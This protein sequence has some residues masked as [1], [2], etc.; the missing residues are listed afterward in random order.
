MDSI[1][2]IKIPKKPKV[3]NLFISG[4]GAVGG[5]YGLGILNLIKKLEEKKIIKVCSISGSSIGSLLG[6]YYFDNKL[7]VLE[8]NIKKATK[9][10]KDNKN[11]DK[12]KEIIFDDIKN[13][14]LENVNKKLFIKYHNLEN[15][16]VI[17]EFEDIN[18]LK[19][20][21]YKSCFLPYYFEDKILIDKSCD[22]CLP[23]LTVEH[24][25]KDYNSIF[26]KLPT[27]NFFS[28]KTL[29]NH[30]NVKNNGYMD[31]YNFF[32][33]KSSKYISYLSDWNP[34]N[35]IF[36]RARELFLSMIVLNILYY[37]E[38]KIKYFLPSSLNLFLKNIYIDIINLTSFY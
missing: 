31:A 24:L 5:V 8:N 35:Y 13:I 12:L 4:G 18:Q 22:C 19:D 26:I 2:N 3:V 37:Y 16:Q 6:C 27:N 21:L 15:K 11:R 23:Y 25:N 1:I 30:K 20:S 17:S 29:I 14:N 34:H 9:Y 7:D 36:Y 38:N 10:I 28:R 32:K 33:N